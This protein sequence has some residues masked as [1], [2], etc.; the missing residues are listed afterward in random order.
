MAYTAGPWKVE[1]WEY[2]NAR[3]PRKELMIQTEAYVLA[4]MQCD[5]SGDN[6]YTIAEQEARANAHL[7]AAAP[8]LVEALQGVISHNRATKP[9]YQLP[10]SLIRHIESALALALD[11]PEV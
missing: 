11:K 10:E 3:P 9:A 8:A 6:P 7:I 2:P 1:V 5:F 4:K